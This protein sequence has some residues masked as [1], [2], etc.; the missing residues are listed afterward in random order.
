MTYLPGLLREKDMPAGMVLAITAEIPLKIFKWISVECGNC[1]SWDE[2]G[3][4]HTYLTHFF[5]REKNSESLLQH[6]VFLLEQY[7]FS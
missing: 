6:F 2:Q 3:E 5:G 4:A 7:L 1:R